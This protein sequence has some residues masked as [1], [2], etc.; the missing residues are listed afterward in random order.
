MMLFLL[1]LEFMSA[2]DDIFVQVFSAVF[3]FLVIISFL[4]FLMV[5]EDGIGIEVAVV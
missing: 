1:V 3:W 2:I 4:L 5:V